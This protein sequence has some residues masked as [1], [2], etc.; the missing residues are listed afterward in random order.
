MLPH[1]F[2]EHNHLIKYDILLFSL[3]GGNAI[4]KLVVDTGWVTVW[5]PG[6][7]CG[8]ETVLVI[9]V[10][11][12]QGPGD[13]ITQPPQQ[14]Q[15][16]QQQ[17]DMWWMFRIQLTESFQANLFSLGASNQTITVSSF[18][19]ICI[20]NSHS[21]QTEEM[22]LGQLDIWHPHSKI[23]ISKIL[24]WFWWKGRLGTW[25]IISLD[26]SKNGLPSMVREEV[27][28]QQGGEGGRVGVDTIWKFCLHMFTG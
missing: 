10:T 24:I 13:H 20:I 17:S 15:Q 28:R 3:T 1:K 22:G 11:S 18:N 4:T 27:A 26:W 6:P 8:V 12:N 16:Q 23:I 21:Q 5:A 2:H 14:Q 9:I 7:G 19:L 25:L